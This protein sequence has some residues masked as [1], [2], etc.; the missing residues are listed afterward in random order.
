[1]REAGLEMPAPEEEDHVPQLRA[2]L[3]HPVMRQLLRKRAR[4]CDECKCSPTNILEIE[5][6]KGMCQACSADVRL[7][8]RGARSERKMAALPVCTAF[9]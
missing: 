1:M 6:C 5:R 8:E 2:R 3:N 9:G 4:V 7:I